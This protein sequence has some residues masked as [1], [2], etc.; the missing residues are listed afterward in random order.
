MS[1]AQAIHNLKELTKERKLR[2][3]KK[4]KDIF[5]EG[6][7]PHALYH[8]NRGKVKTYKTNDDGKE[9]ITGLYV[10]GDFFG[11]ESLL[12]GEF[13]ESA[14]AMEEAELA[15]IPKSDF[16]TLIYGNREVSKKFI[17]ILCDKVGE[18]EKQLLDLAYNTV[19]QRTATALLNVY[20]KY[21][22]PGNDAPLL[23]SREDL[24]NMVGTATETVIRVL[25]DFKDER[26]IEIQ[27]GKIYVIDTDR[28]N[29]VAA[30]NFAL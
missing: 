27:S 24:A 8:V 28:L 4:K 20:S 22:S 17:E 19:Q 21:G 11:F 7:V 3:Y 2:T 23:I 13:G 26:L 18:K 15:L 5:Q 29:I 10:E 30:R 6:D 14:T 9:L 12:E 25:S 1:D 16:L